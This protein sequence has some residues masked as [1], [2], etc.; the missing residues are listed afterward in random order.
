MN[1]KP[2]VADCSLTTSW[3]FNDERDEYSEFT[4][5]YCNKFRAVVPKLWELEIINVILTAEKRSRLNMVAAIRII[6]FLNSLPIDTSNLTFSMHE[7]INV[8]RSNKLTSYDAIY[9]MIAMHEGL[10]MATRD[11]ALI[12]A[13][14]DNGVPLLEKNIFTKDYGNF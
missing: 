2:F 14:G 8:A 12:K 5:N 4:L 3:F 1:Y 10:A 13:C 6:D 7:I 9:L 11:K